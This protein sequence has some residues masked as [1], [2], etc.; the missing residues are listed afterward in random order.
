MMAGT[1]R[2]ITTGR[3]DETKAQKPRC[4]CLVDNA[5]SEVFDIDI[6]SCTSLSGREGTSESEWVSGIAR[7][8][9]IAVST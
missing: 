2:I 1:K 4:Y 8:K 3:F 6:H 7:R 9:M 5:L